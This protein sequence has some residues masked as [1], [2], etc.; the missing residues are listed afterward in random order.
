M[1][2]LKIL[3]SRRTMIKAKPFHAFLAR[4][5]LKGKSH[6]ISKT[7]RKGPFNFRWFSGHTDHTK[8]ACLRDLRLALSTSPQSDKLWFSRGFR[9]VLFMF[10]F[11]LPALLYLP[12]APRV[13]QRWTSHPLTHAFQLTSG[14]QGRG[15]RRGKSL[16]VWQLLLRGNIG[17]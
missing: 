5:T 12:L 9:Q 3:H 10:S 17:A 7:S 13:R 1:T 2:T 11:P 15:E 14:R 4:M 6:N 8:F 16:F